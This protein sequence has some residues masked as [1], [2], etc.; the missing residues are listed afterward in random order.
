MNL[1]FAILELFFT[2]S[3]NVGLESLN[4]IFG[5][6]SVSCLPYGLVVR[7]SGSHPEGPGSIPGM[8]S[9]YCPLLF[10]LLEI[11]LAIFLESRIW[12]YLILH[13]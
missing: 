8:G 5:Y 9:E 6:V 12:I 3:V 7:I 11:K 2:F 1:N 4:T 13:H 10:L